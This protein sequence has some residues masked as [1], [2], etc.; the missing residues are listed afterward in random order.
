MTSPKIVTPEVPRLTTA[1]AAVVI[2][3]V[4]PLTASFILL[5]GS[6]AFAASH[7]RTHANDLSAPTYERQLTS[8]PNPNSKPYIGLWVQ[9]Y[10]QPARS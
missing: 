8:S 9:G 10:P 7:Y 1:I 2:R 5:I 3:K 4:I 6:P